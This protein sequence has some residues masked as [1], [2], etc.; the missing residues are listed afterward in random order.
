VAASVQGMLP[1]SGSGMTGTGLAAALARINHP[2][3]FF[4]AAMNTEAKYLAYTYSVLGQLDA[5]LAVPLP[6]RAL[7]NPGEPHPL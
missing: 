3:P 7:S 1:A 4:F 5:S 6:K 2:H